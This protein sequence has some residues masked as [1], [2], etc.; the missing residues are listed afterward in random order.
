MAFLRL[1]RGAGDRRT[2]RLEAVAGSEEVPSGVKDLAKRYAST[3][4]EGLVIAVAFAV[5]DGVMKDPRTTLIAAA[6][7][8]L[9]GVGVGIKLSETSHRSDE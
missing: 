4:L 2:A 3:L 8:L 5:V 1:T 9:A 6:V 7:G